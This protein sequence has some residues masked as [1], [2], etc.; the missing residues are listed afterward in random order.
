MCCR[1]QLNPPPNSIE[2]VVRT[3]N[4][5]SSDDVIVICEE[6]AATPEVMN[7]RRVPRYKWNVLR[8]RHIAKIIAEFQPDFIEVHQHAPS[9]KSI[10]RKFKNIPSALYRHNLVKENDNFFTKLR[11]ER[12]YSLFSSHIFVSRA[13]RDQFIKAFPKFQDCSYVVANPIDFENWYAPIEGRE[14]IISFAGRAAP[15]KGIQHL[16]PALVQ[17]LTEHVNWKA[18]LCL[19]DWQTHEEWATQVITPLL[20][21][22]DRCRIN[23]NMPLDE[24]KKVFRSTKIAVVPSV[25]KE[26]FGLVAIEAQAAGAAVI[27]SGTGGLLEASGDSALYLDK[28]T[29]DDIHAKLEFLINSEASRAGLAA[30]GQNFVRLHHDIKIRMN[31]LQN[32]RKKI[33][34]TRHND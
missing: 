29:S 20:Q 32:V 24:V 5:Q 12:R 27:S 11:H 1:D 23:K 19:G 22:T 30:K 16:V 33:A 28:V 26:P 31:D 2:T 15:E 21:F 25:W 17:I 13:A 9:G 7:V 8:A 10:T 34:G 18:T 4:E 14:N 6:G 3:L